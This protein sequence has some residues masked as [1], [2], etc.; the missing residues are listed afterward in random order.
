MTSDDA[1]AQRTPTHATRALRALRAVYAHT[2]RTQA[3]R[4][5]TTGERVG[6][7]IIKQTV[8]PQKHQKSADKFGTT[9]EQSG[10]KEI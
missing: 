6:T 3:D 1:A 2:T 8:Q 4:R 9:V 7:K 5:G 10:T